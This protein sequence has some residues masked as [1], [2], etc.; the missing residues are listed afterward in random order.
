MLKIDFHIHTISTIK[1]DEFEF[2]INDLNKYINEMKLDCI[3]ITNH[4]IFDKKQFQTI[5]SCV[6]AKVFPGLEVD[7][8]NSHLLIIGDISDADD[9]EKSSSE[10]EK[11]IIDASSS[12][13]FEEFITIFPNYEKYLLIP[14]YKKHPR[15]HSST[16]KKFNGLIKCGEVPNAKKFS[17]IIKEDKSLVPVV[18]SDYRIGSKEPIPSR[19]T[20]VN[21]TNDG[22]TN[23][24][25]AIEDKSKVSVTKNNNI[26]EIEYLPDGATIS[27]R[28]N[29]IVGTRTSGKTYNLEKIKETF[30]NDNCLYVP[31]FSLI[32]SAES[33]KE[34]I[35][36]LYF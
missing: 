31:Q 12:V 22:F 36:I 3:A 16:I 24:K 5:S 9:L 34:S 33:F 26:N 2:D 28:L 20:Y 18:F 19:Y 14:H 32:G 11:F 8:E 6:N 35:F 21:C 4:N 29:I 17:I 25:L 15:M 10:L 23:I 7:I 30:D 1:D 27:N 13:T